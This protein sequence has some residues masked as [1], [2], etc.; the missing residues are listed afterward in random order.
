MLTL[1]YCRVSTEEQ[2]EEGF[3]IEGQTERLRLY[4]QLRGLGEV[5][6]VTDPGKSGKNMERPGLQQVLA[7]VEAGHV[8]HVIIW[9]LDRL[10]R[11][12]SDL[13]LLADLLGERGVALH[14]V[15]ENLDLSSAAG[16]MFY[17]I[18]GTF[19]QYFR[20]QLSENVR[21]GTQRAAKEGKWVNRPKT[22]YDL[23]DKRLVVNADAP[24]VQEVFRLRAQGESFP[25]IEAAT[26]IKYSTAR[27]IIHSRIY[28]GEVL[29]G[30]TWYDGQHEAI[31]TETEWLAANRHNRTGTRRSK[32][33]LSGRVLCGLC[34]RRMVVA[35][36]G[37]GQLLYRCHHR[38]TGCEIKGR[39][40][41]GLQRAMLL[42]LRLIREDENLRDAIRR[43]LAGRGSEAPAATRTRRASATTLAKLTEERRKL[44]DLYFKGKI[45]EDGFQ[46][47][48]TRIEMDIRAATEQA[49]QEAGAKRQATELEAKFEQV[50]KILETLDVD[51]IWKAATDLER[52]IL[53]DNFVES[54]TVFP[55]H[56]EITIAGS[57]PLI[58]LPQEVGLQHSENVGVGGGT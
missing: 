47:A 9:R 34:G 7:A 36:N 37:Q 8:A 25:K 39:S 54:I 22:G 35:Q 32:D 27:A 58:V 2:A 11:N 4:A 19:A 50:A 17:N 43:N 5:T 20:E 23:V 29:H 1:A 21:M 12:L 6:V 49:R 42:G 28:L 10:S 52:K 51:V 24:R 46:E 30:D 48:E 14:S 57:P 15:T 33:L 45:S 26:G 13:I 56:F 38:G 44:L 18:L 40:N 41:I 31:V 53:I 16:R 3:S 55:E